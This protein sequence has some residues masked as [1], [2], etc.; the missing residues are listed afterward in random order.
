VSLSIKEI[1]PFILTESEN[2]IPKG[3]G[4]REILFRVAAKVLPDIHR[5]DITT[6]RIKNR[7]AAIEL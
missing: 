1:V 3:P 6:G 7:G 5:S 2:A 4:K